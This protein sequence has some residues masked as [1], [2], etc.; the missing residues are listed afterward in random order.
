MRLKSPLR[1]KAIPSQG[2]HIVVT[3]AS[4][5]A[6]NTLGFFR[7]ELELEGNNLTVMKVLEET[8]AKGGKKS[9]VSVVT[10][11]GAVKGKFGIFVDGTNIEC[12]NRLDT[13]IDNQKNVVVVEVLSRIA[14]G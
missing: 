9:L 6:R 13:P 11:N 3:L 10:E 4:S 1:Q 2:K 7:K 5:E 14:G 8:K 12:L